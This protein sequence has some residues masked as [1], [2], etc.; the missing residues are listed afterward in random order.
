MVS[1]F[2]GASVPLRP[3]Q[4]MGNG[5]LVVEA[6][7]TSCA[8]ARSTR[9]ENP[10]PPG[11][12]GTIELQFR[13]AAGGAGS[14]SQ[15]A[16][17]KTND[18][19]FPVIALRVEGSSGQ[20]AYIIPRHVD[21]DEIPLGESKSALLLVRSNADASDVAVRQVAS[22]HDIAVAERCKPTDDLVH[23][24]WRES[25]R[26]NCEG[27]GCKDSLVRIIRVTVSSQGRNLGPFDDVISVFTNIADA[28]PLVV[29]IRG[30]FVP[31]VALSPTVLDFGEV[32]PDA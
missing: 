13:A 22:L 29:S 14:F 31:P 25:K 12:N 19:H 23:E 28:E 21:L 3:F 9:P 4:N 20:E 24:R 18:P 1:A 8:C 10:I 17:V 2:V 27:S 26:A 32:R 15:N 5:A 11:G 30:S 7:K 6:V 16:I